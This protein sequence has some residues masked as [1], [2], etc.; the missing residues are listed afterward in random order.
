MNWNDRVNI[1][2]WNYRMLNDSQAKYCFCSL[3]KKTLILNKKYNPCSSKHILAHTTRFLH[4]WSQS[5]AHLVFPPTDGE[6]ADSPCCLLL[7]AKVTL[8]RD[9]LSL[10]RARSRSFLQHTMPMRNRNRKSR[11][12][13]HSMSISFIKSCVASLAAKH[14]T[15]QRDWIH[16]V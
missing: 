11:L 4:Q 15:C 2:Y 3:N 13:L 9:R 1:F 14:G 5:P 8:W 12:R 16:T 6:V 7:S 10:R